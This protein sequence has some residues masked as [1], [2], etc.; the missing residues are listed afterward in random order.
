MK[1]KQRGPADARIEFRWRVD[2]DSGME[3]TALLYDADGRIKGVDYEYAK[4]VRPVVP[5]R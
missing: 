1:L 4:R 3:K 2:Q 5:P